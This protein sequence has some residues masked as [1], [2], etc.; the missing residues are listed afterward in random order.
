MVGKCNYLTREDVQKM[1]LNSDIIVHN[2][3]YFKGSCRQ[4][5]KQTQKHP[6][7]IDLV[8]QIISEKYPDYADACE[9]VFSGNNSHLLNVLITRKNVFDAYCEW[10]F[11]ILFSVESILYKQG[12]TE[13]NR[14]MGMLG[15]RLLD[16]WILKNKLKVKECFMI[17][18]ERIDWKLW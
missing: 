7:D 6:E 17:N 3:T 2:R 14:R 10:L 16:I 8:Q 1:L 18:T 11:D 12:E 5:F 4:Q 13:F 9:K 15:E